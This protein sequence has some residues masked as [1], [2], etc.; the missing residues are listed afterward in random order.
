M[1]ESAS[2][3]GWIDFSS[4]DRYRVR[5]A[6]DALRDPGA[7]DELGIGIVRDG[8]SN[9]MFPGFSTIQTRAKYL[10]TLP[11]MIAA[12]IR[13]SASRRR[14]QDLN[15]YLAREERELARY[16]AKNSNSD[17]RGII[18]ENVVRRPSILYWSLLR[19]LGIVKRNLSLQQFARELHQDDVRAS[20]GHVEDDDLSDSALMRAGVEFPRSLG[21][22]EEDYENH[23]I[24]LT[25]EEAHFLRNRLATDTQ[26]DSLKVVSHLYAL[27][28][29]DASDS[30]KLLKQLD[31]M[32]N[33]K[34]LS[35]ALEHESQLPNPLRELLVEASVFSTVVH[36]AY[37]RF[38][39]VLA[40]AFHHPE[41]LAAHDEEWIDWLEGSKVIRRRLGDNS[42]DEWIGKT[43]LLNFNS[44]H[45][46]FLQELC[47][48]FRQ[49][50][51][52]DL[53]LLDELVKQRALCLKKK[54]SLLEKGLP[55]NYK[56][57]GPRELNYRWQQVRQIVMDVETALS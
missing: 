34:L 44:K 22:D 40:S 51:P 55:K 27:Y 15:D 37:I 20:S 56:W 9:A 31:L 48:Q 10:V 45:R 53:S 57:A 25:S 3:V 46:S 52:I 49:N 36:G 35:K 17:E 43:K 7:V 12:Y 32:K 23:S 24:E 39:C 14:K 29:G 8:F 18:G 21:I 13:Q 26:K 33:F 30:S 50:S 41:R 42:V 19:E 16:L 28:G 5:D 11:R 2:T 54:R 47:C 1:N 38:N 6:L 4:E